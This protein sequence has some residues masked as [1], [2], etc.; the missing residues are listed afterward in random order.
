MRDG[1]TQK[2]WGLAAAMGFL[3]LLLIGTCGKKMENE[4]VA[5]VGDETI[6]I[7]QLWRFQD[8]LPEHLQ[9]AETGV[10]AQRDYLKSMIDRTI[11]VQEAIAAG[12]DT[13]SESMA[14]RTQEREKQLAAAYREQYVT[15]HV[16]VSKE[17]MQEFFDQEDLGRHIELAYI[18][19]AS[20]ESA[21]E[22]LR[23]LEAGEKF[24]ELAESYSLDKNS[25]YLGGRSGVFGPVATM[26]S[27][28]KEAVTGLN[29]GEMAG[30][31]QTKQ[32][33]YLF[34]VADER[35]VTLEEM[36]KVEWA[37][38]TQKT[39]ARQLEVTEAL[40]DRFHVRL[41]ASAMGLLMSRSRSRRNLSD[42]ENQIPLY[43]YDGG[44]ISLGRFVNTALASGFRSALADSLK[45]VELGKV[46]VL[47]D[48][49]FALAAE[50]E[51]MA[52]EPDM[53]RWLR[54]KEKDLLVSELRRIRV[55]DTVHIP[56][57]T[58][59]AYYDAHQ[60]RYIV[61]P[62]ATVQEILVSTKEEA[63]R[64][65]GE[66]E[67]GADIALL[68]SKH[69]LRK[70][71]R[72]QAGRFEVRPVQRSALGDLVDAALNADVGDLVGPIEVKGGHSVFR[73]VE[74]LPADVTPFNK[75]RRAIR[76]ML[77]RDAGGREFIAFIERLRDAYGDRI[78]ISEPALAGSV[79][80]DTK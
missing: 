54:R 61:N 24:E 77:K 75:V 25:R 16:T 60:E 76:A 8:G 32:G 28:I 47:P 3:G 10:E 1:T 37:V 14:K 9:S 4:V 53:A 44:E 49:L 79:R 67:A 52:E 26:R 72:E 39:Y 55:E 66:I 78:E 41:D 5:R 40:S 73:V 62:G 71:M 17:E 74:R 80:S 45:L 30:P 21:E 27:P 69:T 70:G 59:R 31:V 34:K 20:Q 33:H 6:T 18:V 68:A 46:Y 50:E 11:M 13:L 12:L 22:V 7:G 57:D 36:P 48:V 29:V 38:R 43:I 23:K 56:G 42:A 63:D 58:V 15:G 65:H 19:V 2:G 64:L 51:G 35:T